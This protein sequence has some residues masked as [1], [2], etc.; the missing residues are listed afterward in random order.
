MTKKILGIWRCMARI[1]TAGVLLGLAGAPGTQAEADDFGYREAERLSA[2]DDDR[3][4]VEVLLDGLKRA[5]ESGNARYAFFLARNLSG[6]YERLG[7]QTACLEAA[8]RALSHLQVME[9]SNDPAM[10]PSTRAFE[11]T[12]LTGR[13]A[14]Y[15]L[16]QHQ[17][18]LARRWHEREGEALRQMFTLLGTPNVALDGSEVPSRFPMA[19]GKP[20]RSQIARYLW[21]GA[22]LLEHEA[23]TD[24]AMAQLEAAEGYLNQ[25]DGE[26]NRTERDYLYKIRNRKGLLLD[27]LGYDGEAIALQRETAEGP[28]ARGHERSILIERLNLALGM[29]KHHGPSENFLEDAIEAYAGMKEIPGSGGSLS[30]QRLV[31][32]MVFDLRRDGRVTDRL[33][34]IERELR[35][36][37]LEL[38]GDF[39]ELDQIRIGIELG[40]TEGLEARLMASLEKFRDRG[41]RKGMPS[42]YREYGNLLMKLDRP[43]EAALMYRETLD[44]SLSHG[45]IVHV[46]DIM[47]KLAKAQLALGD[48]RGAREWLEAV[49]AHLEEHPG[50]PVHR[51]ASARAWMVGLLRELGDEAIADALKAETLAFAKA[52]GV[53]GYRVRALLEDSGEAEPGVRV[54]SIDGK[55]PKGG[56]DFQPVRVTSR[57]A[58]GETAYARFTLANLTGFHGAGTLWLPPGMEVVSWDSVAGVM[59]LRSREGRGSAR[60]V[61][62]ELGPSDLVRVFMKSADV[63]HE[64]PREYPFE[65]VHPGFE[66]QTSRWTVEV[67]DEESAI[68]V[69]NA[70][71]IE[72]NPFY[73]V[74]LYHAIRARDVSEPLRDFRVRCSAPC[75][76]EFLDEAKGELLAVDRQGDGNFEGAGDLVLQDGNGDLFPDHRFQEPG[77]VIELE[78]RVYPSGGK[79][80]EAGLEACTV[81]LEIRVGG[82]WETLAEN[83]MTELSGGPD[84]SLSERD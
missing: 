31:Q 65:W 81:A 34:A 82:D 68:T 36:S 60:A 77:E 39:S 20:N 74:P 83:W 78:L 79:E 73:L 40:E 58:A 37:G 55:A 27:F 41:N 67:S 17:M 52:H 75:Y 84:P 19:R 6:S 22:W 71:L 62:L 5:E 8:E 1:L 44:L 16:L 56:L 61:P 14:K 64:E 26:L 43:G 12:L 3:A 48:D 53:P 24:E 9:Q 76:V 7:N 11:R 10:S 72:R 32:K 57:V 18:A 33:E 25:L 21:M 28:L 45:W 2:R 13:M 49:E 59:R 38:D 80:G 4:A 66:K 69:V 15:H 29:A 46:P 63:R 50:I 54:A 70:N 30:S 35:E 51:V 23:R 42:R 47:L